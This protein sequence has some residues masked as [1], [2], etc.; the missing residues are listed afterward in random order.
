MFEGKFRN[1]KTI[2]KSKALL[3]SVLA[4]VL[5]WGGFRL[6]APRE[7]EFEGRPLSYWVMEFR[8]DSWHGGIP[9][10]PEMGD[11]EVAPRVEHAT[12]AV[13]TIGAK[14]APTLLRML[15]TKDSQLK[16][17][18]QDLINKQSLVHIDLGH[19]DGWRAWCANYAFGI[20]G[21]NTHATVPVLLE[22]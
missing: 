21:T 19:D 14:G 10:I 1:L 16:L 18:L 3:L 20:L 15:H 7:P 17:K 9:G 13:Q 11:P 8:A 4:V 12:L 5:V 2:R 6:L 22:H